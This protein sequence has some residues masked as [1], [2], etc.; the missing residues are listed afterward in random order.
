MVGEGIVFRCDCPD[1]SVICQHAVAVA[2]AAAQRIAQRPAALFELRGLSMDAVERQ[3]V[4]QSRQLSQESAQATDDRFW[5]GTDLPALPD[6][7]VAP[8][9]EDSDMDLL[10]KAMR[11]VSYTA[12]E[13]LRAVAD[14]E[15]MYD[16]LVR[17]E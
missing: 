8:A 7:V 4:E 3:M 5:R 13:Q 17:S 10:H 2:E 9:L 14:I 6:P 16:Y 1:N 11:T 12:V 15:D